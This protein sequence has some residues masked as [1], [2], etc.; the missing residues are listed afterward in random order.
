MLWLLLV[1]R[2]SV[3]TA[4]S[5]F[6]SRPESAPTGEAAVGALGSPALL[7]SL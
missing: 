1:A 7:V 5:H 2:K 6:R 4:L 3:L